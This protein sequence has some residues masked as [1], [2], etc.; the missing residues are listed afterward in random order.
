MKNE[1]NK[2]LNQEIKKTSILNDIFENDPFGLL[3]V[4]AKNQI[5][6][7]DDRLVASFEEINN[8]YKVHSCEPKKSID[9]NERRLYSRLEGLKNDY[10]KIQLLKKYDTYNLLE[11]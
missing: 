6:T 5:I 4:K 10:K 9:M 11:K 3:E 7:P 2:I 8:F 1:N